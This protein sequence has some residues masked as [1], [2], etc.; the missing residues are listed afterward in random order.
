MAHAKL[1]RK[2]Y[3]AY[4]LIYN[5]KMYMIQ[6]RG[7]RGL[8]CGWTLQPDNAHVFCSKTH[9][10]NSLRFS[11]FPHIEDARDIFMVEVSVVIDRNL[12]ERHYL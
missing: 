3:I 6:L 12:Y 9:V 11:R 5:S 4:R 7:K 1:I 8:F 10:T 2:M